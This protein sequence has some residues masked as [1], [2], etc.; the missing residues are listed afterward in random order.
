[1]LALNERQEK[2]RSIRNH[3]LN[4][5]ERRGPGRTTAG[6]MRELNAAAEEMIIL[7]K[8][9][10]AGGDDPYGK[11]TTAAASAPEGA[12]GSGTAAESP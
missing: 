1:M 2:G 6:A 5:Q 7:L 4:W 3:L 9:E 12:A 10:G 8:L 11:D